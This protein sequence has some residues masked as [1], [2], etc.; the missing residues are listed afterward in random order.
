MVN[1]FHIIKNNIY[2]FG[3]TKDQKLLC[4]TSFTSPWSPAAIFNVENGC[5]ALYLKNINGNDALWF[6]DSNKAF[7]GNNIESIFQ[8]KT[9][10]KPCILLLFHKIISSFLKGFFDEVNE[11]STFVNKTLSQK[12]F[13]FN[14]VLFAIENFDIEEL[15]GGDDEGLEFYELLNRPGREVQDQ[16]LKRSLAK[17]LVIEKICDEEFSTHHSIVINNGLVAYPVKSKSGKVLIIFESGHY[18]KRVSAY[19]VFR[20]KLYEAEKREI[21]AKPSFKLLLEHLLQNQ[22]MVL[23]YLSTVPKRKSLLLRSGLHIGH[24]LWNDLTGMA[25]LTRENSIDE[26]DEVLVLNGTRAEPWG[27][28][29]EIYP[30]LSKVTI[31]RSISTME[32]SQHI[33]LNKYFLIRISDNYIPKS[34]S[35]KLID[36]SKTKCVQV[37]EKQ[38][39][40]LRVLFGLRFENRTWTNQVEGLISVAK[41]LASK[42]DKLSIVVDGHD[43]I[44]S[45]GKVYASHQE[46]PEHDIISLEKNV[47]E[48]LRSADLGQNVKI[49]DSVANSLSCSISLIDS[50]DFFIAPW[51]AGLAKY[52]WICNKPGITF[53]SNIN[54]K[55]KGDLGIYESSEY[56]QEATPNLWVKSKFIDDKYDDNGLID[57]TKGR[58][59]PTRINFYVDTSGLFEKIDQILEC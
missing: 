18:N 30:K 35:D 2:D 22:Q 32:L 14:Q 7:I 47:I 16:Y 28:Y 25:R 1:N 11:H 38:K 39:N 53:T 8:Y 55:N 15:D 19:D 56:R 13:L 10:L 54:L 44:E 48:K 59:N 34:L 43:S 46:K 51:G 27:L 31:N 6:F 50:S 23:N 37:P 12:G 26:A 52:K 20:E 33:Y 5:S 9:S 3:L 42:V 21:G 29:D 49:I 4:E 45:T 57:A 40:E 41:Y 24:S 17:A 36:M 58:M